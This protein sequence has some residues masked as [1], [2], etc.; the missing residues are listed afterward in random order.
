VRPFEIGKDETRANQDL[1][2]SVSIYNH[3][4]DTRDLQGTQK[5]KSPFLGT[6]IEIEILEVLAI[7]EDFV[8][9]GTFLRVDQKIGLRR[10]STKDP[11]ASRLAQGGYGKRGKS[12]S[13]DHARHHP[14][15]SQSLAC[16]EDQR[17]GNEHKGGY[18]E[19]KGTVEMIVQELPQEKNGLSSQTHGRQHH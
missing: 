7:G 9:M 1:F 10:G 14:K 18:D 5:G 12:H 17:G 6:E 4:R 13:Q 19:T 3:H 16:Q 11:L 15:D 2:F 8:A